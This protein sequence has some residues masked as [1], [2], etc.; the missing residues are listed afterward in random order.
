MEIQE[1]MGKKYQKELVTINIVWANV[2]GLIVLAIALVI[3]G[4]PYF[5]IWHNKLLNSEPNVILSSYDKLVLVFKN[6]SFAF[7][8]LVLSIILHELIHGIF[9]MI[10]SKNKIKSIKFGIMPADK[11][12][13]PY[14]H[15]KEQLKIWHY[16]ISV[17]M[18]LIILGI[19]PAIVSIITGNLSIFIFGIVLTSAGCGDL[20]IFLKLMKEKKNNYVYDHPSEA[21]YY[22]YRLLEE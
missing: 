18:P 10:F 11:L 17:M 20:L 14:C 9:F 5:L 8:F 16:K 19:V 4:L 13:T 1:I 21:G 3:F 12:F 15:C 2:F 22:V 7:L 6:L